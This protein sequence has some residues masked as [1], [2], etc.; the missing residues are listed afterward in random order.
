MVLLSLPSSSPMC[1]S[2]NCTILKVPSWR[3]RKL[4]CHVAWTVAQSRDRQH[5]V[6]GKTTAG[7]TLAADLEAIAA[8][9]RIKGKLRDLQWS[10]LDEAVAWF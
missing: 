3:K 1:R 9:V 5:S 2:V 4:P 8:D 10:S 7:K 6:S